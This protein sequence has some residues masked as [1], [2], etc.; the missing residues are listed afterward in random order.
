MASRP[1]ISRH[2]TLTR[3]GAMS[4]QQQTF[5][6]H[7]SALPTPVATQPDRAR[8]KLR[9][10]HHIMSKSWAICE[11]SS[12]PGGCTDY[13]GG[14][15]SSVREQQAMRRALQKSTPTRHEHH[16]SWHV[17]NGG[18]RTPCMYKTH[19]RAFGSGLGTAGHPTRHT[20][21]RLGSSSPR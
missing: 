2:G 20:F 14:A 11:C 6:Q 16:S 8:S 1:G 18:L 17:L 21:A 7:V 3:V 4:C 13:G 19:T 10:H 5:N 15:H 9:T 12:E